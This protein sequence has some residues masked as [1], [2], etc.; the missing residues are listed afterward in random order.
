MFCENESHLNNNLECHKIKYTSLLEQSLVG[1][2]N[3]ISQN[4]V[5]HFGQDSN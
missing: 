1:D 5:L 3:I 4:K 2:Q